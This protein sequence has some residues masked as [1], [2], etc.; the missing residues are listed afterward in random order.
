MRLSH[1]LS[2]SIAGFPPRRPFVPLAPSSFFLH[3]GRAAAST[4]STSCTFSVKKGARRR[5]GLPILASISA[6]AALQ[7]RDGEAGAG[8]PDRGNES[9]RRQEWEREAPRHPLSPS[10]SPLSTVDPFPDKP[11]PILSSF[12]FESYIFLM[13]GGFSSARMRWYYPISV[14]FS[15]SLTSRGYILE[16][17]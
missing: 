3:F 5:R 13:Y 6:S 12:F 4:L 2:L 14:I 8:A 1:L 10:F 9:S 15:A 16:I 17:F 11:T 7:G